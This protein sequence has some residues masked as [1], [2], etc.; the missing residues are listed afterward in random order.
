MSLGPQRIQLWLWFIG[1]V[2]MTFPRHYLGRQGQWRRVATFDYSVPIIASWRPW[3]IVS[4][5]GGIV[6]LASALSFIWNLLQ[7]RRER[8]VAVSGLKSL[9]S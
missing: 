3:V 6:L 5:A 2:V 9:Y 7:F 4:F 1:M 8:A